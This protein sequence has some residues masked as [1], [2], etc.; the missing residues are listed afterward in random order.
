[1]SNAS[2]QQNSLPTGKLTGKIAKISPDAATRSSLN[3]ATTGLFGKVP[4]EN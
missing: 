4:C 2:Q 1:M 3:A